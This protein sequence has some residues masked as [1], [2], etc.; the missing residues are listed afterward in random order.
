MLISI[1]KDWIESV[2]YFRTDTD[3]VLE[4]RRG[5]CSEVYD[6]L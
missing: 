4:V 6:A 3:G 1:I 5:V 2:I